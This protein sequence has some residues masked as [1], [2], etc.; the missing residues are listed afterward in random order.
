MVRALDE[1]NVVIE[2]G[3]ITKIIGPSGSG[4]PTLLRLVALERPTSGSIIFD[5]KEL[6]RCS[7]VEL[8]IRHRMGFIFQDFGLISNLTVLENITYP[9]IPR[10][11]AKR[12][13]RR[14]SR[15]LRRFGMEDRRAARHEN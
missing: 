3:C 5:G 14:R 4:K 7:D 2:K 12:T 15:L 10:R 1:L 9:L 13:R 6:T 11:P 8:R